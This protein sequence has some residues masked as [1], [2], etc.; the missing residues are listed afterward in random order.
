MGATR[1]APAVA[2]CVVL[3]GLAVPGCQAVLQPCFDTKF[4]DDGRLIDKRGIEGG[5]FLRSID[6]QTIPP[7]G[8]R[9]PPD[10]KKPLDPP[11]FL[12]YGSLAFFTEEASFDGDCAALTRSEGS[13]IA[14]YG[15]ANIATTAITGIDRKTYTGR[16]RQNHETNVGYV[17]AGDRGTDMTVTMAGNVPKFIT[18]RAQVDLFITEITYTLVFER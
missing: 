17:G 18:I 8:Y 16:F 15:V 2:L 10:P 1:F 12:R 7:T 9:L 14:H 13:A 4:D 5:W 6:G 3:A 11:K